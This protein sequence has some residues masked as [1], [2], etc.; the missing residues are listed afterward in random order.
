MKFWRF[1]LRALCIEAIVHYS[2]YGPP[3]LQVKARIIA[4]QKQAMFY[5]RFSLQKGPRALLLLDAHMHPLCK[6]LCLLILPLGSCGNRT[7]MPLLPP[8][9]VDIMGC[10]LICPLLC[11]SHPHAAASFRRWHHGHLPGRLQCRGRGGALLWQQFS[12]QDHV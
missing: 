6:W 3:A 9:G 10:Q 11:K 7:P 2:H 8:S 5:T 4:E 12:G 1:A